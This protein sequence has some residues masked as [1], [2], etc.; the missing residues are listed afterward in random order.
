MKF[1]L[2]NTYYPQFSDSTYSIN[3]WLSKSAYEEQLEFLLQQKFGTSDFQSQAL[4]KIGFEAN[5]IIAN[6]L[7]LQTQWAI[8]N[9]INTSLSWQN[10][11]VIKKLCSL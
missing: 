11:I 1:L 5:D 2:T 6:N 7:V 3:L 9:N 8:E 10:F 4:T